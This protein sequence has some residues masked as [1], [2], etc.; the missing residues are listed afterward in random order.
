MPA[1]YPLHRPT[2]R[3]ERTEETS[4]L[5]H[6]HTALEKNSVAP[7]TAICIRMNSRQ[8]R[9]FVRSGAGGRSWRFEDIADRL[10]ADAIAQVG[11]GTR[12][13]VIALPPVLLS[14]KEHQ[15]LQLRVD[16]GA[17][18]K[19]PVLGTI[20]LLGHERAVPG[21]NGLGLRN[22]GDLFQSLFA[23]LLPH[24]GEGLALCVGKWHPSFDLVAQD[25]VFRR[26]IR[27]AQAEFLIDRAGD[28][29]QQLLPIHVSFHPSRC[30]SL[31][32][33]MGYTAVECKMRSR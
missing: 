28:R 23:E 22:R 4:R 30:R 14:H 18:R 10:V 5:N 3:K 20:K 16:F 29:R 13:V 24:L 2:W 1:T 9:V 6:D 19:F 26:Q 21:E 32:V 8:V 15:G 27:M 31:V 17:V 25:A 12:H 11:H 33:S 7:T